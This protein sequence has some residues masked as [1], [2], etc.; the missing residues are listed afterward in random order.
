MLAATADG[1]FAI[2]A[3]GRIVLWNRAAESMLG[4]TVRRGGRPAVLRPADGR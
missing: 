1:G 4:Y 3:V 2:D